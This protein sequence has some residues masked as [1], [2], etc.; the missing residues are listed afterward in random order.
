MRLWAV[1]V[2]LCAF[3]VRRMDVVAGV[4][5]QHGESLSSGALAAVDDSEVPNRW[6]FGTLRRARLWQPAVMV[7]DAG[8]CDRA[9]PWTFCA[10]K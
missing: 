10:F 3:L 8:M 6:P 1:L 7:Y 5:Q 9:L 2:V 4:H